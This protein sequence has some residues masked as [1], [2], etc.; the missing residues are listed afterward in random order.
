M[1]SRH[2][3]RPHQ[4]HLAPRSGQ[5]PE[6]GPYQ[7]D[8]ALQAQLLPGGFPCFSDSRGT[9]AWTRAAGRPRVGPPPHAVGA[10]M[11]AQSEGHLGI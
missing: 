8:P 11:Q 1:R 2:L 6:Q 10:Q 9:G 5:T 3:T 4:Q 7:G